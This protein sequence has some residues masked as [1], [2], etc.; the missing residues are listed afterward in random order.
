L[1]YLRIDGTGTED[2]SDWVAVADSVA[3]SLQVDSTHTVSTTVTISRLV[4]SAAG[5]SRG[6]DT[7]LSS[8]HVLVN[9]DDKVDT[10]D[11]SAGALSVAKSVAS[12]VHGINGR[13]ASGVDHN[14]GS[15]KVEDVADTVTDD[16]RVDTG[17]S[18]A[19]SEIGFLEGHLLVVRGETTCEDGSGGAGD[20]LERD[21]GRLESLVDDFEQLSLLGVHPH[22]LDG[23]DTEH[24]RVKVLK[25]ALQEVTTENV[26]ATRTLIVRVEVTIDV[27]TVRR[28][29]GCA[30]GSFVDHQVP[31]LGGGVDFAGQA[32]T[33][34]HHCNG[35]Q[36]LRKRLL[37]IAGE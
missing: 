20:G 5:G 10:S 22:G 23:G 4:K 16:T 9:S 1:E 6:Q 24:G 19:V 33:H 21:T 25:V 14:T 35:L 37:S 13:R 36:L 34:S 26:E 28:N 8:V 29:F 30:A 12:I 17:G 27:E 2:T 3:E 15:V 7:K 18:V 31:E 32:A 11:N